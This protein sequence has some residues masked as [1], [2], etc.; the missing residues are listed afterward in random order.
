MTEANLIDR[1]HARALRL[2]VASGNGVLTG[3]GDDCAIFRQPGSKTDL[4]FTAD[5][6]H[7]SVHF[8][9]DSRP[10]DVGHIALTRS[11]SD[12]AAM[13]ARPL[14]ALLSLAFPPQA[15]K[16]VDGFFDG[17][18]KLAKR[19]HVIL[20]GG[21]LS[22]TNTISCDVTVCGEL[23]RGKALLRSAA[24]PGERICVSG[25]LGQA[26][27]ALDTRSRF[28]PKPQLALGK[29]LREQGVKCAMDL[30]DGLSL[31]LSRL[32][33]AS[34]CAADLVDVPIAK[35]ASLQHALHGGE[36]YALLFT[37]SKRLPL[38]PGCHIIGTV[39]KG[40]PGSVTFNNQPLPPRGWDHFRPS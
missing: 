25:P 8:T 37:L 29:L 23:P 16:W 38:P 39:V 7:E 2:G 34:G 9:W 26:A 27:L 5:M 6:M 14:F 11:L 3:I 1:I 21:D 20:A 32:C 18:L 28:L 22:S 33:L 4:V 10:S 15:A 24:R 30:S 31:D 17:F 35:G 40:T 12:C 13:G 19:H 36:D